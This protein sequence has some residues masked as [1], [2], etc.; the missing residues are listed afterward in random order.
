LIFIIAP[1]TLHSSN[2]RTGPSLGQVANQR[3]LKDFTLE[4]VDNG[5]QPAY[6]QSNRDHGVAQ[7]KNQTSQVAA[8]ESQSYTDKKE[9][10]E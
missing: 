9:H 10:E 8:Y 6:E 7:D 4:S 2:P 5:Y 1:R 3:Q